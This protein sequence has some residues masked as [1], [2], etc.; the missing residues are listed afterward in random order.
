[1]K[2]QIP[3]GLNYSLSGIPYW[4]MDIGGFCVENRYTRAKEGSPDLDEWRELN[5][6]WYQFGSF[7][8]LFRS[9]GQ[10]PFREIFNIS[11]EDHPAYKSM[12]YY[13]KLRYYLM[14]YIYSLAGLTYFNDY[15]IMRAMVMDFGSDKNVT[16]I[17]DQYMFGP[18][19]LV[20]PVYRYR[21][22]TRE[23]YLPASCGW[24]DFYTG[25]YS[26]GGQKITAD[27]PY[28]RIPLFVKEG[29]ILPA[30]PEIQYTDEKPADPLTLFVYCGKDC[31]F[32]LYEDEG[33]NYNYEQGACSTI[34]FSYNNTSG[35]LTIG[36]RN[37][38]FDGMLKSRTF[39]II[40]I[41]GERPVPF[42]PD[43]SPHASVIYDGTRIVIRKK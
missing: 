42:N 18:S 1:M 11:P 15:T 37:G 5:T 36:D 19:L 31:A 28:D 7:C 23:V 25:K 10:Y 17:G 39:R 6:R 27:A 32:T 29:T 30:G 43:A 3:A 20:A 34:K 12:V 2:A 8:P 40:W 13:D 14:P 26:K 24:Y 4:T 21:A 35:E 16:D 38:E 41:T 9:H 33:V 22:R